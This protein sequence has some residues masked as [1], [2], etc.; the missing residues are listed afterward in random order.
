MFL[1]CE[2]AETFRQVSA[3]EMT[4]V[5]LSIGDGRSMCGDFG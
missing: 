5:K 2:V 1:V 3:K 4:K